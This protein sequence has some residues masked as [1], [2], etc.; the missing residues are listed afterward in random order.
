MRK[1]FGI[2]GGGLKLVGIT[3]KSIPIS[4]KMPGTAGNL[5][6]NEQSKYKSDQILLRA[7]RGAHRL[8]LVSGTL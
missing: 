8:I 6:V 1:H 3:K 7:T 4:Q 5:N 2:F